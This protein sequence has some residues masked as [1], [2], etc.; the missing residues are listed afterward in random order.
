MY[1]YVHVLCMLTEATRIKR[2]IPKKPCVNIGSAK[3]T[4]KLETVYSIHVRALYTHVH[5]C[6]STCVYIHVRNIVHTRIRVL[7]L[8]WCTCRC[9]CTDTRTFW[10]IQRI[11]FSYNCATLCIPGEIC[12]PL[13]SAITHA[14]R[15]YMM[16]TCILNELQIREKYFL[17]KFQS[18][19]LMRNPVNTLCADFANSSTT[20]VEWPRHLSH[21]RSPRAHA[22]TADP[23]TLLSDDTPISSNISAKKNKNRARP[24]FEPGTSRTLSENHTP[25]PTSRC[26]YMIVISYVCRWHRT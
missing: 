21:T 15:F 8:K 17:N 7:K 20:T 13:N 19:C 5:D 11:Y 24:G 16:Y 18:L 25:R 26:V 2:R 1:M 23:D 3:F 12:W 6:A 4:N 9:I 14:L 10:A 22:T